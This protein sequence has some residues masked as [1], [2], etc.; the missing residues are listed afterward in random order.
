MKLGKKKE[1]HMTLNTNYE[2]EKA[3]ASHEG[4]W[5]ICRHGECKR[6]KTCTGGPRGTFRKTGGVPICKTA[7]DPSRAIEE[8]FRPY[9]H[10]MEL[11]LRGIR[12]PQGRHLT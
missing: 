1:N 2:Q 3:T 6:R 10:I 7:I 11:E 12:T 4:K 5:K 9:R 8:V